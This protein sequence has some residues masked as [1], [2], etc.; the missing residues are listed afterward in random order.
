[1]ELLL[2]L[3]KLKLFIFFIG[4]IILVYLLFKRFEE[5]KNENFEDREY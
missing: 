4:A 1:M 3:N 5:K 2:W